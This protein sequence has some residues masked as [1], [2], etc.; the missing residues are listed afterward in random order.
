MAAL[1]DTTVA[2][3]LLRRSHPEEAAEVVRAAHAEI[4]AGTA[5][6]PAPAVTELVIG[7]R[8]ERGALRLASALE[9]LPAVVLPV[10]AARDAG[11]MGA[12]LA[13]RGALI[14]YPDLLIAATAV[15]LD[16]PLLTWDGDYARSRTL[17]AESRPGAPGVELWR[18]LQLHPASR[19]A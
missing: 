2:V 1:F 6:V 11:L 18:R 16:V 3:L 4:L 7:E 15:W 8:D 14:P 5:L 10:E 19:S 12:F 9:R 17:S 13:R